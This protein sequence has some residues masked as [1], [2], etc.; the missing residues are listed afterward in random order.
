MKCIVLIHT[1]HIQDYKYSRLA[2]SRN[3]YCIGSFY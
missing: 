3:S 2:F 1:N